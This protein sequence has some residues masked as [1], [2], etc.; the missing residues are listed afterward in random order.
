[1]Q[2]VLDTHA[3]VLAATLSNDTAPSGG[4]NSDGQTSDPA[5]GGTVADALSKI[6]ALTA[7]FDSTPVS[8]FFDVFTNL[9]LDSSGKNGTF[10]LSR[11]RL[12]T[13][14][15][16]T[17]A[18]GSHTLHLKATDQAGNASFFDVFFTLDTAAPIVTA[19]LVSDTG[20]SGSDGITSNSAITGTVSDSGPITVLQAK[21][22]NLPASSFFDIFTDLQ[23]DGSFNLSAARLAEIQSAVTLAQGPHQL[24]I[25]AVDQVGNVS[26]F[27]DVFFTL[28]TQAPTLSAQL[29]SDSGASNADGITSDPAVMGSVLDATAVSSLRAKVDDLPASSFFDIFTDLQA[30]GTFSLSRARLEQI[31]GSA[32]ADG[33]HQVRLQATDKA[34]NASGFFDV[35]FTLD[36]A[37]PSVTGPS[38]VYVGPLSFFDVFYNE[39]MA[40]APASA[41]A[42]VATSY[43]LIFVGGPHNCENIPIEIVAL[44][45]SSARATP[46][47]PLAAEN[48]RLTVSSTVSDVAGNTLVEPRSF[49][50][51]V[52]QQN[53]TVPP[54]I[55]AHL[56]SDTGAS[57]TDRITS[58]P[59]ITG[60]VHDAS[61]ISQFQA[62]L[63]DPPASNFIDIFSDLQPDGSFTLNRARLETIFGPIAEGPHTLHLMAADQYGNTS[64][65][66]VFFNLDTQVGSL[67]F[68]LSV[69]SDT[70][71]AGDHST[72]AAKVTLVGQT[73]PGSMVVLQPS[74]A[75]ALA[76]STGVFQFVD[77][78]L[79]E[80]DNSFTAA[81]TDVAGNVRNFAQTIHR[82]AAATGG[83]VVLR[84]NQRT[85]EAV[86]L[87]ATAAAHCHAFHGDGSSCGFR[88]RQ[89]I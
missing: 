88:Y 29:A 60:S 40:G 43:Q 37:S 4:T 77:V 72:T 7:G 27:F 30:D 79:A 48:Y 75:T 86:R 17:L 5:I 82:E 14:A 58:D 34:G 18:D 8:S 63:D 22:D 13:I 23:A 61:A 19:Q 20:T 53:E 51:T 39:S 66:D 57:N 52:Q 31:R 87:D 62:K 46:S 84:W 6:T 42:F 32:L 12:N 49:V 55:E 70:A 80:G 33:S 1:M 25:Q 54:V 15:G 26:S 56:A 69:A 89:R 9:S 24:R 76:S 10:T 36:T 21:V 73:D 74:G 83:D 68:D 50:F 78:N 38:G 47:A 64:F 85:L 65:F 28:D 11:A 41:S 45:L 35:F 2:V 71:P 3:P 59:T 81:A 16:G 67:T 44:D